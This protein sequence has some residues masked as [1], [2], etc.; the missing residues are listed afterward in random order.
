MGSAQSARRIQPGGASGRA[1]GPG[2]SF[3]LP[4]PPDPST[5][6]SRPRVSAAAAVPP[7]SPEGGGCRRRPGGRGGAGG[8]GRGWGRRGTAP[9][10]ATGRRR[11]HFHRRRCAATGSGTAGKARFGEGGSGRPPLSVRAVRGTR[12]PECYSPPAAALAESR[13]R[14]RPGPRRRA[15]APRR[16]LH[17]RGGPPARGA[18]PRGGAPARG[19]GRPSRGATALPPPRLPPRGGGRGRGGLSPVRPGRRRAAGLGGFLPSLSGGGGGGHAPLPPVRSRGRAGV[20]GAKRSARG[21]RRCRLPTRPVLKH[22]PRSLTRARV[23]GSRESRRGAMKVKGPV[24][25]VSGVSPRPP[26]RPVRGGIP[27]PLRSAEG[28]PPAR[29]A[30]RAGEVEQERTR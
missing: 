11:A 30:R 10:P 24:P 1:G 3:P 21:R 20:G 13:G 9:R 25:G 5:R 15:L 19:P 4:V 27:R 8:R 18:P 28:A 23:R 7:L 16:S 14:G 6:L 26:L 12:R 22:G 17:P 2:G 29:L